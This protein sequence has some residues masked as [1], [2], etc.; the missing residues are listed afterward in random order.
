[1]HRE[2]ICAVNL[3][4][5]DLVIKTQSLSTRTHRQMA[6]KV[7]MFLLLSP[8]PRRLITYTS[9]SSPGVS[10]APL[11]GPPLLFTPLRSPGIWTWACCWCS[12]RR[13]TWS[14]TPVKLLLKCVPFEGVMLG[15]CGVAGHRV[16][17]SASESDG[18]G[19][20]AAGG[21]TRPL[22]HACST[23]V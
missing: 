21:G 17:K 7:L 8:F 16:R 12:L 22:T 9:Y 2:H 14:A 11:L 4:E 23:C 3:G 5:I 20:G 19:E 10:V 15:I 18:P 6:C 13:S 1:M